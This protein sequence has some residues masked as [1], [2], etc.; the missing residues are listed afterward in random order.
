MSVEAKTEAG[1]PGGIA[2]LIAALIRLY[3]KIPGDLIAILARVIIGLVFWNSGRTKV[4]GFTIK[5]TTFFLFQEE[6]KL[7]LV[8]PDIAAYMATLAEHIFPVLIWIGLATRFSATALLIMTLV[9]Q[10]F[11]YPEAYVTHGLWAV[12]LLF[13]MMNG[14]GVLSIDHLLKRR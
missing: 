6:Y 2:G 7:P 3:E 13:I 1:S 4:D 11:V 5:D 12:A 10:T 9:I 14:P 8:P